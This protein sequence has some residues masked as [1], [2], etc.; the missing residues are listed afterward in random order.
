MYSHR[1]MLPA[2]TKTDPVRRTLLA[3]FLLL[4]CLALSFLFFLNQVIIAA[5]VPWLFR[6]EY[7]LIARV[8]LVSVLALAGLTLCD[9]EVSRAKLDTTPTD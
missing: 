9:D 3:C 6:H 7:G 5:R 2:L 1:Q 4:V 8:L